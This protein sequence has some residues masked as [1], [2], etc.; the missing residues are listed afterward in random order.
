MLADLHIRIGKTYPAPIV[1]HAAARETAL[2]AFAK[3]RG[4]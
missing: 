4:S 2:A 1:D 3:I